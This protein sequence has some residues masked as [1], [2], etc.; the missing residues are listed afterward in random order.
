[1]V[2]VLP[3]SA[4]CLPVIEKLEDGE[5]KITDYGKLLPIEGKVLKA[6]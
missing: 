6:V 3:K 5:V 1:V 2:P 4:S